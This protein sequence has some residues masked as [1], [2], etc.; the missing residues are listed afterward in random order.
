MTTSAH[1]PETPTAPGD[2]L[3]PPDAP[4]SAPIAARHTAKSVAEVAP[5]SDPPIDGDVTDT[6]EDD[7]AAVRGD[8]ESA[9]GAGSSDVE[10]ASASPPQ[11][12]DP[13]AD[14]KLEI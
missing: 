10:M 13:G 9:A 6:V 4:V 7:D 8:V 14:G 2:A 11:Q 5:A 3:P 12:V 1:D